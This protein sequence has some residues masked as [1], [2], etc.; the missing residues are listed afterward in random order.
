MGLGR[1]RRVSLFLSD[2]ETD[3]WSEDWLGLVVAAAERVLITRGSQGATE[4]NATGVHSV[5]IVHV[6]AG[7]GTGVRVGFRGPSREGLGRGGWLL[8]PRC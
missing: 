7:A 6:G 8:V 4:Y 3:P 5:G 1:R 2:V